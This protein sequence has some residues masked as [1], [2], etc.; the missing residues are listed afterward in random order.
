[1][2]SSIIFTTEQAWWQR[3]RQLLPNLYSTPCHSL[4]L[5]LQNMKT[6]F[7]LTAITSNGI[8]NILPFLWPRNNQ[9]KSKEKNKSYPLCDGKGV[10]KNTAPF[11]NPSLDIWPQL[12][13]TSQSEMSLLFQS[14]VRL[15]GSVAVVMNNTPWLVVSAYLPCFLCSGW[16]GS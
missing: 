3:F 2:F 16:G 15:A 14:A 6:L 4:F 1:M 13:K 11:S 5:S 8:I 7:V 9:T 10:N 12:K